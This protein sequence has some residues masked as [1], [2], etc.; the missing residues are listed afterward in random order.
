MNLQP[1]IRGD[2]ARWRGLDGDETRDSLSQG[3]A[4]VLRVNESDTM[5]RKQRLFRVLTYDRSEAPRSIEAWFVLGEAPV[6]LLEYDDPPVDDL[7]R[8]LRAYG[9]PELIWSRRRHAPDA[10]VR[11]HIYAR[12]GI[13]LSIAEPLA[14]T[15]PKDPWL[16][17]VQLYQRMDTQY[18][19]ADIG[20]VEGPRPYPRTD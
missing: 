16:V 12:R 5:T 9:E 14:E 13:T 4:P 17:H 7:N 18:Y 1:T 11:E 3:L 2:L 15:A 8:T 10:I 19:V 20:S 6:T